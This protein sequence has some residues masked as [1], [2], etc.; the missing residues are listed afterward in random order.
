MSELRGSGSWKQNWLSSDASTITCCPEGVR[1]C[2]N[3]GPGSGRCR[4]T[5]VK[6]VGKT[7]KVLI[8]LGT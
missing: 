3:E 2:N 8:M 5:I 1:S 6:A 7:E 4:V